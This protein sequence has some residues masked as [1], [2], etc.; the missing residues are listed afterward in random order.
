[1]SEPEKKTKGILI[2]TL[3]HGQHV[4]NGEDV[5]ISLS[6]DAPKNYVRIAFKCPKTVSIKRIPGEME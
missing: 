1:M 3:R 4:K 6:K 5:F 2:L